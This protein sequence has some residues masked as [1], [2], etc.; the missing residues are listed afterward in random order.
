[1]NQGVIIGVIAFILWASASSWWYVC[2]IKGLCDDPAPVATVVAVPE[3]VEEPSDVEETNIPADTIADKP[4][5]A[6]PL[7]IALHFDEILFR[8]NSVE[9][10]NSN[11]LSTI[12]IIIQ[13]TL[14]SQEGSLVIT[15]YTCDLGR[16]AYNDSLGLARA[17]SIGALLEAGGLTIPFTLESKGESDPL[18][19]NANEAERARNRR[20]EIDLKS[21][22]K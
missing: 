15:G 9:L 11:Q 20:V 4:E 1:M 17:Q 7:P 22:P 3:V 13:D 2:K 16:E 8:K 18:N 6:A 14:Q 12:S 5:V 10:V 21:N 19:N